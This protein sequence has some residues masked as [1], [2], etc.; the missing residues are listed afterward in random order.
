MQYI[1]ALVLGCLQMYLLATQSVFNVEGATVKAFF[2]SLGISACIYMQIHYA[3][4][5]MILFIIYSLGGAVG[6]AWAT[7]HQNVAIGK[8]G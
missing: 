7:Y 5:G 4:G 1:I 8:R 6:Q 2:N 3:Q